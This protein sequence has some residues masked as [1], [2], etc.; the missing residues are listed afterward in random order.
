MGVIFSIFFLDLV[1]ISGE[2]QDVR[3]SRSHF[4][5]GELAC[6]RSYLGTNLFSVVQENEE[7][8][9]LEEFLADPETAPRGLCQDLPCANR[10]RDT[11][12]QKHGGVDKWRHEDMK[13]W[14]HETMETWRHGDADTRR[15]G[16]TDTWRREDTV[17]WRHSDLEA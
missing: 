7:H 11:E 12:A 13:T 2:F 9:T 15:H 16:G 8:L 10:H 1:K 14:T 17:T 6:R 4:P 3:F 5:M